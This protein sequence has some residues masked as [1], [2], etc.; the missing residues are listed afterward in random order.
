MNQK[1]IIRFYILE[2]SHLTPVI[3]KKIHLS[4]KE[5]HLVSTLRI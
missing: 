2:F 3:K 5:T 1:E 4:V